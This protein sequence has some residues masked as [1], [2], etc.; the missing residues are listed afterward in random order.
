M[1]CT[2][3][4]R[5]KTPVP[6]MSN[7]EIDRR[8]TACGASVRPRALFC[9]QCGQQIK[10][11]SDQTEPLQGGAPTNFGEKDLTVEIPRNP[12]P[13]ISETQPIIKRQSTAELAATQ[14]LSSVQPAAPKG[15]DGK[16]KAKVQKLRKASSVVIDQAAYD[17]S[18]RFVLVGA[19]IFLFFLFLLLLSKVLG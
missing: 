6:Y 9:P 3:S 12:V 7:P 16:V 5:L 10:Q 8:C 2:G 13:Y 14:P 11:E 1:R 19:A 15:S 17:P 4:E 18:L